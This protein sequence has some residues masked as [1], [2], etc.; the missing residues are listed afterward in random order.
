MNL[1]K[2][3]QKFSKKE[4]VGTARFELAT[5]GPPVQERINYFNGLAANRSAYVSLCINGLGYNYKPP[6]H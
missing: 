4:M 1:R 3:D 2:T 6:V 5:P